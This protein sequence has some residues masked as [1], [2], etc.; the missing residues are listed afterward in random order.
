MPYHTGANI[1]LNQ[2]KFLSEKQYA[3]DKQGQRVELPMMYY[4]DNYSKIEG[5]LDKQ[6]TTPMDTYPPNAW[7]LQDMHG[8]VWEFCSDWSG[9]YPNG[10]SIDPQGPETGQKRVDRGGSWNDKFETCRSAQRGSFAPGDR[11]PYEGFRVV[12]SL[13]PA[14]PAPDQVPP[15][16]R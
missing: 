11:A 10:P 14:T 8:N 7:G 6:E 16:P 12:V 1:N 9:N 2:A 3:I 13:I 4:N 5:R 15:P